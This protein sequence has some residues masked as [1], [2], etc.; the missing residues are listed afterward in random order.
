MHDV[1]GCSSIPFKSKE[2]GRDLA[3]SNCGRAHKRHL[4]ASTV[5]LNARMGTYTASTQII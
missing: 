1:H 4:T 5:V 2:K 3:V